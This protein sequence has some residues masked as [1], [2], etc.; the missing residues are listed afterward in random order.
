MSEL[1]AP[2]RAAAQLALKGVDVN[3][4]EKLLSYYRRVRD[5]G[6]FQELVKRLA[7]QHIF[8][9][10]NK[11]KQYMDQINRTLLPVLSNQPNEALLFLGWTIRFMRYYA[12][13]QDE[14]EILLKPTSSQSKAVGKKQKQK[15]QNKKVKRSKRSK[16]SKGGR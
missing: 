6:K 15:G 3:E 8:V 13:H 1:D 4:V 16:R 5:H 11:T 7:N 12:K 14:A 2:R 10:S 9:Y